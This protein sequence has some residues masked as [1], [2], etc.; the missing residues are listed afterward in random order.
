ME[1]D[2]AQAGFEKTLEEIRGDVRRYAA[3]FASKADVDVARRRLLNRDLLDGQ[4]TVYS[5]FEL[6]RSNALGRG[7]QGPAH[8]L[9]RLRAV[10]T[11]Q[12]QEMA[13]DIFGAKPMYEV[14]LQ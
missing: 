7:W 10:T 5:A 4:R 2:I 12:V 8:R 9:Q 11:R 1:N 6:A 14:V 3:G 13:K